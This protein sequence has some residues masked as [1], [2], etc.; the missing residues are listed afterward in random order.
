MTPHAKKNNRKEAN[1]IQ[2]IKRTLKFFIL[3]LFIYDRKC[4][5]K[6]FSTNHSHLSNSKAEKEIRANYSKEDSFS[7]SG[8][9]DI[10]NH[11]INKN[12]EKH[13]ILSLP[14]MHK[15]FPSESQKNKKEATVRNQTRSEGD[16]LHLYILSSYDMIIFS[17]LS[18]LLFTDS[19]LCLFLLLADTILKMFSF[20]VHIIGTTNLTFIYEEISDFLHHLFK[21]EFSQILSHLY[22]HLL[23]NKAVLINYIYFN[24][25]MVLLFVF[26][27]E[28]YRKVILDAPMKPHLK[29][30]D[31]KE[32][33]RKMDQEKEEKENY[34]KSQLRQEEK[35]GRKEEESV[36]NKN[37]RNNSNEGKSP[38]SNTPSKRRREVEYKTQE[39][40]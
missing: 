12:Y 37:N 14:Y 28:G 40:Y 32:V 16:K 19:Y 2:L 21:K 33:L 39:K 25:L 27:T 13:H 1:L 29:K 5:Y 6:D 31:V 36:N 20:L 10:E 24:L 8:L 11:I 18:A 4:Y 35:R 26:I 7:K 3:A 22:D 38:R 23:R 15:I 34:D 9:D 17:I 30:D